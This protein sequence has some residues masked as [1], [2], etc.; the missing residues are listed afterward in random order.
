MLLIINHTLVIHSFR[1]RVFIINQSNRILSRNR[2][3]S[4]RNKIILIN[5]WIIFFN[6]SFV[7]SQIYQPNTLDWIEFKKNYSSKCVM[8]VIFN[9][10]QNYIFFS[11]I[12]IFNQIIHCLPYWFLLGIKFSFHTKCYKNVK[13]CFEWKLHKI[14]TPTFWKLIICA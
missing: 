9:F 6:F 4:Q 2:H 13:F 1:N 7:Q 10:G 11:S 3:T 12:N 5:L 14:N 8:L